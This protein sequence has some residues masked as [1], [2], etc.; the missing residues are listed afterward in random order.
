MSFLFA[1]CLPFYQKFVIGCF[2]GKIQ[3]LIVPCI[4]KMYVYSC[5]CQTY[6]R[7]NVRKANSKSSP[8]TQK[9]WTVMNL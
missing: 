1:D 9:K 5:V 6:D 7:P 4:D 2:S 8:K 3:Y